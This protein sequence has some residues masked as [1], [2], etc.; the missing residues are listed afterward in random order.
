MGF[1][2]NETE[3]SFKPHLDKF[4][5]ENGWDTGWDTSDTAK[6]IENR[7][8]GYRFS[9]KNK[10]AVLLDPGSV[11][12]CLRELELADF[13]PKTVALENIVERMIKED[14]GVDHFKYSCI[15]D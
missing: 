1:F 11:C 9:K 7:Y 6:K 8:G 12:S 15:H 2:A 14:K 5:E 3:K 10:D 13:E 4:F